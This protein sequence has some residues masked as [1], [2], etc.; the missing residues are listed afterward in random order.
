MRPSPTIFL[1]DETT[2]ESELHFAVMVGS[3]L[4]AE[5]TAHL[6]GYVGILTE[7]EHFNTI[8]ETILN[9]HS[10]HRHQRKENWRRRILKLHPWIRLVESAYDRSHLRRVDCLRYEL[11]VS[12]NSVEDCSQFVSQ[13]LCQRV[14]PT[15]VT[16][17]GVD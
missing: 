15:W 9:Q 13:V 17:S 7:T 3:I 4:L 16:A 10:T 14:K 1:C 5:R 11:F 2:T 6:H 12:E 8:V